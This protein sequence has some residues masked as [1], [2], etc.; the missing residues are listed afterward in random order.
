MKRLLLLLTLISSFSFG[1]TPGGG[2]TDIDGNT[3]ETVII[4]SQ[5]WMAENLRTTKY[6]NGD[7]I[8]NLTDNTL[9]SNDTIGAWCHFNNDNQYENPYGKLYNYFVAVDE[10]NVCP[11]GWRIPAMSDYSILSNC[12]GGNSLSGNHLKSIDYWP[13]NIEVTNS[14]GYTALPAGSRFGS[15]TF[16]VNNFLGR[17]FPITIKIS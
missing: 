7:V 12:L 4:G 8:P 6:S 10:R 2:V 1:Q 17:K 11:T 14:S 16:N 13:A 15:G 9:W 5:E 3:Y